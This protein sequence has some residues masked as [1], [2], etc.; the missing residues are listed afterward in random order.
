MK[1]KLLCTSG[2]KGLTACVNKIFNATRG[3]TIMFFRH[4]SFTSSMVNF[5]DE[6]NEK[7]PSKK[8][9]SHWIRKNFY[10]IVRLPRIKKYIRIFIR[11]HIIT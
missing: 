3:V 5:I 10:R 2:Y 1:V 8:A 11:W 4:E 7:E 9:V 6:F